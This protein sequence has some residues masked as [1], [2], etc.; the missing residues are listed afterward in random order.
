MGMCCGDSRGAYELEQHGMHA[1]GE[2]LSKSL[3]TL[4]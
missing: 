1:V 2:R 3:Q 4:R